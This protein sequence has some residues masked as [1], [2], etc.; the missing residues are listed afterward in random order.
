MKEWFPG[1]AALLGEKSAYSDW[2]RQ[3][4]GVGYESISEAKQSSI[5]PQ[6]NRNAACWETYADQSSASQ[7][8]AAKARSRGES[9]NP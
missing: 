1:G 8:V 3:D 6:Y 4:R 7:A 9:G 5:P 2:S